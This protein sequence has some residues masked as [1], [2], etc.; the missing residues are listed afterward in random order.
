M[1][2]ISG[3]TVGIKAAGSDVWMQPVVT[4]GAELVTSSVLTIL[5][6]LSSAVVVL[7]SLVISTGPGLVIISGRGNSTGSMVNLLQSLH[8]MPSLLLDGALL[9]MHMADLG[10]IVAS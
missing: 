6:L 5:V 9:V 7:V 10:G 4:Y 8:S 3:H 2:F 1:V